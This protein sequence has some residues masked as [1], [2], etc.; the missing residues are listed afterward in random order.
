MADTT[1]YLL[2]TDDLR[3]S[4]QL[5][6]MDF[7]AEFAEPDLTCNVLDKMVQSGLAFVGTN[8]ETALQWHVPEDDFA[9]KIHW[10][11]ECNTAKLLKQK[12]R[13]SNTEWTD[14]LEKEILVWSGKYKTKAVYGHDLP[15]FLAR[16]I[17][18][19]SPT[20]FMKLLWDNSRT[21][22]YNRFCLERSNLRV[23]EDDND[24]GTKLIKTE[25]RVPFTS[26][27]VVLSALMHVRKLSTQQTDDD[28]AY[29]IVSRSLNTGRAGHHTDHNGGVERNAQSEILW[30][31]NVIRSVPGKPHMT[32]L[33]CLSQVNSCLV[34]GF[35]AHRVG[36]MAVE[37]C[38]DG[39]RGK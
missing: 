37:N 1:K 11:A 25:T 35:L 32:D 8:T 26:M 24:R 29:I 2:R 13:L 28:D 33:T 19:T 9:P 39:F 27:T 20:D 17:V 23:L 16:G 21:S 36:M 12:T 38:F 6:Y 30:G 14:L 18:P 4:V 7:S 15:F 22:E 31:V 34:P 5:C 10:K 3:L